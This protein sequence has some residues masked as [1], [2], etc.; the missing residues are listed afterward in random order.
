MTP[1]EFENARKTLGLS[2]AA[3]AVIFKVGDRTVRRWE[4][5]EKDIPGPAQVLV[6]LLVRSPEARRL[7]G[8]EP[9]E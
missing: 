6:S 8:I 9:G 7:L 5:G 3:V 2:E 1:K 4:D